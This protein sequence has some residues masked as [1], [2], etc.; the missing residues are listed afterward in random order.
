MAYTNYTPEEAVR[1]GREIYNRDIR[2]KV[3]KDNIGRYIVIN[4]ENG[5]Y[6]IGD[7]YGELAH[8]LK[9]KQPDAALT[10]LKIGYRSAGKVG[11]SW[12]SLRE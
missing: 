7:D 12:E 6:E 1:L 11:G 4:I 5:D 8:H 9:A 10:L 3:E 2:A